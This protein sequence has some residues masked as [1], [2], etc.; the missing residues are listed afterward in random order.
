[1]DGCVVSEHVDAGLAEPRA[2]VD[3]A[4]DVLSAREAARTLLGSPQGLFAK[5]RLKAR[6]M[7]MA[8]AAR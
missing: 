4:G 2:F 6:N 7:N 3:S 8:Y 1:M 5:P